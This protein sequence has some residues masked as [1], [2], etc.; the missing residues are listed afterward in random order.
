MY[1]YKYQSVTFSDDLKNK[2]EP[3][4]FQKWKSC[5]DRRVIPQKLTSKRKTAEMGQKIVNFILNNKS[6]DQ[7]LAHGT[8]ATVRNCLE[9]TL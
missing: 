3:C 5:A 9:V 1:R 8:G 2:V 7:C 6:F 4:V